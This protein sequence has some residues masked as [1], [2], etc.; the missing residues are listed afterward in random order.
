MAN[1]EPSRYMSSSSRSQSARPASPVAPR[2]SRATEWPTLGLAL[3]IYGG[4][5]AVTYWHQLLPVWVVVPVGAWLVA[6]HGSLQHEILHGHPTRSQRLN[7]AL[8]SVPLGLWM[9]FQSYRIAHLVHHRDERL[10][11][12]LDDPESY[13]WRQADWEALGRLGR[14]LVR[15]QT[16]LLG[17]IIV[18]PAWNI[19][20]FLTLEAGDMRHGN[21]TKIRIWMRH[22]LYAL[23]VI[24][25][26]VLVCRMNL[27]FYCLAIVYPATSLLVIRSFAEHRAAQGVF[28]RTAI[29]EN[30]WI[31]GPLFLFNNLH[32]AH[33]EFPNLPW[34]RLPGWYRDNR[35][36]LVAE[37]GGLVYDGYFDVVRRFLLTPHDRPQ[38]P[39]ART[40]T[41][42]AASAPP[43]AA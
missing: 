23:P 3:V 1:L 30:S 21:R 13:Y 4:W 26:L 6:W 2:R 7:F 31:L 22:A 14:C 19:S 24:L 40:A 33:H 8:G 25:W 11:D 20:R 34:Y 15:L 32:A 27:A 37:N 42:A 10:T 18:G 38:H 12:P 5:A 17:R 29:V 36:R 28:E 35:A 41:A 9:P 39:F 16:T 43:V